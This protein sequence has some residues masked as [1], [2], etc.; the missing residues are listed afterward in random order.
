[1]TFDD[2]YVG[3]NTD[4]R[5]HIVFTFDTWTYDLVFTVGYKEDGSILPH[6][7]SGMRLSASPRATP[8]TVSGKQKV[9]SDDEIFAETA[10]GV[11]SAWVIGIFG[12]SFSIVTFVYEKVKERNA[13]AAA[14]AKVVADV[15]AARAANAAAQAARPNQVA[16][17]VPFQLADYKTDIE[18]SIK[19]SIQTE[20]NAHPPPYDDPELMITIRTATAEA[21]IATVRGRAEALAAG[22]LSG[23]LG[24]YV[25]VLGANFV[26]GLVDTV[27]NTQ[28]AAVS[29][30][31]A[32]DSA[33]I[34]AVVEA[35]IFRAEQNAARTAVDV[36]LS[37]IR[38]LD[39]EI[40]VAKGA[41]EA[42]KSLE[43]QY[44]GTLKDAEKTG[45]ALKDNDRYQK[46]YADV[47]AEELHQKTLD[48][49][50]DNAKDRADKAIDK[51]KAAQ[52]QLEKQEQEA[53]NHTSD[54]Y[55]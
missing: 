53:R 26:A 39:A 36:A 24:P 38:N 4:S 54:V 40:E 31:L 32:P 41:A 21:G 22:N 6:T 49:E 55:K 43:A 45:E 48:I 19:A 10:K 52:D 42:K 46:L 47:V 28:V 27:V 9:P 15:A 23:R 3:N 18:N 13:K 33:Y 51:A 14:A 12:F 1:M 37:N 30:R 11:T 25:N 8:E 34:K 2:H 20:L 5:G 17:D 50:R 7:F 35:E 29:L 44:L 16:G